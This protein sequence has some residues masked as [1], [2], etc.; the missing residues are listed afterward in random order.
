MLVAR[1]Q[2]VVGA[3]SKDGH[4]Q[5]GV[6][7]GAIRHHISSFSIVDGNEHRLRSSLVL[8][9]FHPRWGWNHPEE[10]V[11]EQPRSVVSLRA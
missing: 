4:S 10:V 1:F 6:F 2:G 11:A 3:P 8:W 7:V 9:W 5:G